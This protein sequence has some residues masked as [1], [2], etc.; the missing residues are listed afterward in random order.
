MCFVDET[1]LCGRLLVVEVSPNLIVF[2][3]S[4]L[5]CVSCGQIFVAVGDCF[6]NTNLSYLL[7][8]DGT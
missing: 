4:K 5:E 3:G 1:L 2:W 7:F 8:Y 6:K